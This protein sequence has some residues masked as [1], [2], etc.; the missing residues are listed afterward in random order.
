M[1]LTAREAKAQAKALARIRNDWTKERAQAELERLRVE[2]AAARLRRRR[3]LVQASAS[4][5]R[6]RE[7][8]RARA[9][10]YRAV[11][12]ERINMET[13]RMRTAATNA[14][15]ARKHRIQSSTNVDKGAAALREEARLQRQLQRLESRARIAH[16]R[17]SARELAQEDDDAV[18]SNLPAE[19]A[20]V[21]DRVRRQI[22]TGKRTTRTEAFLEWAES[23]PED[24]LAYQQHDTDREVRRLIAE[25]EAV[26][27][28]QKRRRTR[29]AAP[30]LAEVPF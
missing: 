24:V 10:Q 9:R 22:K 17:S 2:L 20:A 18:R 21:F 3:A 11:E 12:L 15:K 16:K 6:A 13:R 26:G 27:K 28:V 5:R 14:C 30:S 29:R 1:G 19:L 23:H 8:M 7:A 25:H 4:C